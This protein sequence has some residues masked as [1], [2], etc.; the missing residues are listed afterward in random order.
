[1]RIAGRAGIRKN[2]HTHILRLTRATMLAARLT[3]REIMLVF[4]WRIVDMVKRYTHLTV[5]DVEASLLKRST[6]RTRMM[7]RSVL[8]S[9]PA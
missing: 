2:V 9:R 7:A 8:P 3:D 4:D 1:M 5:R 6:G